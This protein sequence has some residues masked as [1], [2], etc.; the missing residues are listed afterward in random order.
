MLFPATQIKHSFQ[1]HMGCFQGKAIREFSKDKTSLK[2][3]KKI[4]IVQNIF[5]EHN[6]MFQIGHEL[7]TSIC[8]LSFMLQERFQKKKNKSD[9][10]CGLVRSKC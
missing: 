4:E 6:R 8:M 3:F 9:F 10:S 7:H 5:Y 1:T 2:K